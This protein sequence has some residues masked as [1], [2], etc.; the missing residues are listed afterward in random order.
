MN[1]FGQ[2]NGPAPRRVVQSMRR[3]ALGRCPNCGQGRI[4]WAYL[5]VADACPAC[6]ED[7]SHQRADDA[8]PYVTIFIVCHVVIAGLLLVEAVWPD[9][10][11]SVQILGWSLVTIALSLAILPV[12]K[13]ALIGLQW[14]LRMHGF[15]TP[16]HP[17]A[18]AGTATLPAR[19]GEA[20]MA[21]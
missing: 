7:M 5:K 13:G 10:P 6:G 18:T 21:H 17:P 16:A 9:V 1:E 19:L 3:G 15:D 11:T 12:V 14:A 8:P 20:H 2:S 4:F